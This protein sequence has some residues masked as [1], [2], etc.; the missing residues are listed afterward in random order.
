M[1]QFR[2]DSFE[3]SAVKRLEVEKVWM[4]NNNANGLRPETIKI[5]IWANLKETE[6]KEAVRLPYKTPIEISE[7]DNWHLVYDNLPKYNNEGREIFMTSQKF[8]LQGMSQ[9][10]KV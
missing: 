1:Q 2:F 10:L 9:R 4:D 5:Q 3:Y 6:T 7:I 8:R